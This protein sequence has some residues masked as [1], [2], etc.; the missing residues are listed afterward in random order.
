MA[1]APDGM[2]VLTPPSQGDGKAAQAKTPPQHGERRQQS[3]QGQEQTPATPAARQPQVPPQRTQQPTV[4]QPQRAAAQS[5]QPR[6]PHGRFAPTGGEQEPEAPA[7]AAQR[8][9]IRYQVDGAPVEKEI[10]PEEAAEA[11]RQLEALRPLRRA[12]HERIQRAQ[13]IVQQK[14]QEVSGLKTA[15]QAAAKGDFRPMAEMIRQGGGD[16]FELF[17][18]ALAQEL[19]QG[20]LD[21]KDR[22]ILQLEAEREAEKAERERAA[23]EERRGAMRAQAEK[24]RQKLFPI[25][26]D[27]LTKSGLPADEKTI[28][29]TS[30]VWLEARK[31]AGVELDWQQTAEFVREDLRQTVTPLVEGLTGEQVKALFP[32]LYRSMWKHFH[33]L[34]TKGTRGLPQGAKPNGGGQPRPRP[35]PAPG[36]KPAGPRMVLVDPTDRD[37]YTGKV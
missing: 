16:T 30:R 24:L 18:A 2:I 33:E 35:A 28:A 1:D 15:I 27:V 6:D 34:A 13:E 25:V 9:S 4:P 32:G 36:A 3:Q 5:G 22:R 17:T 14:E 21:E 11:F 26:Q 23:A 37:T 31:D 8:F 12:S 19:E 29:A 20:P 10:T 7:P